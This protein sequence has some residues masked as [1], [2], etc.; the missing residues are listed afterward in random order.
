V[1][2]A[3]WNDQT[4]T[5]PSNPPQKERAMLINVNVQTSSWKEDMGFREGA[6]SPYTIFK[7]DDTSILVDPHCEVNIQ[8]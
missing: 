5:Q 7:Y 4:Q 1:A 2:A 3:E 8:T 6:F